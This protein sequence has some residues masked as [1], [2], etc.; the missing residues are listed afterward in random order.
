MENIHVSVLGI[1][2]Q[3][4]LTGVSLGENIVELKKD[5]F[6]HI[7]EGPT[8]R[9]RTFSIYRVKSLHCAFWQCSHT[10]NLCF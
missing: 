2:N 3:V 10:M 5:W 7:R 6:R 9:M 4:G 8:V 1:K